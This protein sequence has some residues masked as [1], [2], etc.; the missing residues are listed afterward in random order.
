MMCLM[1]FMD[2]SNH[3]ADDLFAYVDD[4]LL[5]GCDCSIGF[6]RDGMASLL[7]MAKR[8]ALLWDW[9]WVAVTVTATNPSFFLLRPGGQNKTS[10]TELKL[11][12]CMYVLE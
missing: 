10:Q 3:V 11:K 6:W 7:W 8:A 9:D 4:P 12:I 5:V 1:G 2:L